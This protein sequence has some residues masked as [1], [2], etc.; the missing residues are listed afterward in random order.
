V[1]PQGPV[2]GPF[3]IPGAII[4]TA[5]AKHPTLAMRC[6]SPLVLFGIDSHGKPKAARF[7]KQH[8]GLARKARN[9]AAPASAGEP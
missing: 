2:T 3:L 5:Q 7:G 1:K 6:P 9:P 4:M 8:A